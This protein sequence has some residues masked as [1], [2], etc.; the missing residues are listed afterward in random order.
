MT[1]ALKLAKDDLPKSDLSRRVVFP[2]TIGVAGRVPASAR[3]FAKEIGLPHKNAWIAGLVE[4][5]RVKGAEIAVRGH[6]VEKLGG[7]LPEKPRG[8]HDD[9]VVSV[10]PVVSEKDVA[11][12]VRD[13]EASGLT[14]EKKDDLYAFLPGQA[15]AQNGFVLAARLQGMRKASAVIS[16]FREAEVDGRK[17]VSY[18]VHIEEMIDLS[19]GMAGAA[20]RACFGLQV[21]ADLAVLAHTLKAQDHKGSVAVFCESNN[22]DTH[23]WAPVLADIMDIA[24]KAVWKTVEF[25]KSVADTVEFE[26]PDFAC[27]P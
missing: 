11:E 17:D 22:D 3:Q 6:A 25:K 15:K 10:W 14:P 16:L 12:L 4:S 23:Q 18:H 26:P 19:G 24:E 8:K 9:A 1:E 5:G 27:Y 21:Q 20:L 7:F 13:L 2:G